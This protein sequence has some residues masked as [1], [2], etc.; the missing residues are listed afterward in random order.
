[1]GYDLCRLRDLH[2]LPAMTDFLRQTYPK[3]DKPLLSK[4]MNDGY[5][6]QLKPAALKSLAEKFD[7]EGWK[8]RSGDQHRLKFSVKCRLTEDE[9]KA[10]TAA[11]R[12][13]GYSSANDCVRDLACQY[14]EA[15]KIIGELL[16]EERQ[17]R[18][19][20]WWENYSKED[21]E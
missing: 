5:G 7:P 21:N 9:F 10:F 3:M 17:E 19:K 6:V 16:E 8:S 20:Q 14:I 2:A 18:E 15:R 11:W 12:G 1:M 4:T 13:A